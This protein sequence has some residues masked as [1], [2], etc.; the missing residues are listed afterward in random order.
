MCLR[1]LSICSRSDLSDDD[2]SE[3]KSIKD[4]RG[5]K[6]R[7]CSCWDD[8]VHVTSY[9]ANI[10]LRSSIGTNKK[11]P[12]FK[13]AKG[14]S[15]FLGAW[16]LCGTNSVARKKALTQGMPSRLAN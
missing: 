2:I 12:I 5:L 3:V 15:V 8:N 10:G 4:L 16:L 14:L 7:T 1:E 13:T 11:K 9:S 6:I